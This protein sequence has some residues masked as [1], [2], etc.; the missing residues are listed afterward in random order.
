MARSPSVPTIN[1]PF[2]PH[3]KY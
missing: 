1:S 3:K 2:S